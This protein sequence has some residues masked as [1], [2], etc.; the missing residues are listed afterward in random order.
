MCAGIP[1]AIKKLTVKFNYNDLQNVKMLF[2]KH[3]NQIACVLLE[4]EKDVEP[5]ANF[6]KDLK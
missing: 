1:K 6:L 4:P 2:D 5:K 3:H